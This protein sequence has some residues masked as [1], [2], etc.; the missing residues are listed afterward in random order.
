MSVRFVIEEVK[1]QTDTGVKPGPSY[2]VL[3]QCKRRVDPDVS[4]PPVP[5]AFAYCEVVRLFSGFSRARYTV[6]LEKILQPAWIWLPT[7]QGPEI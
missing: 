5:S 2:K 3:N 4:R 7:P 1:E 6:I